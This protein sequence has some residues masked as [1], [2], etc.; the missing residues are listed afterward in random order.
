MHRLPNNNTE[1]ERFVRESTHFQIPVG[2]SFFASP[3]HTL[4]DL[5]RAATTAFD[6]GA[7]AAAVAWASEE[8]A[9]IMWDILNPNV[10]I[11][12]LLVGVARGGTDRNAL[13]AAR[14]IADSA[15]VYLD[16][17][18]SGPIAHFKTYRFR[19][20]GGQRL[21]IVT[22]ANLTRGGLLDNEETATTIYDDGTGTPDV[23]KA[24]DDVD[25]WLLN[26]VGSQ[27]SQTITDDLI[28]ALVEQRIVPAAPHFDRRHR[29]TDDPRATVS[30]PRRPYTFRHATSPI[31]IPP[32]DGPELGVSAFN[33]PPLSPIPPESA[34]R[35]RKF[36]RY[37]GLSES[38]RTRTFRGTHEFNFA[39]SEPPDQEFWRYPSEFALNESG[40]SRERP[41]SARFSVG[42]R[43]EVVSTGRVYQRLRDTGSGELSVTEARLR[44]LTAR[45][46]RNIYAAANIT[47][48]TLLVV[49]PGTDVDYEIHAVLPSDA[50]FL[51]LAPPQG[52]RQAY[53]S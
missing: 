43:S 53:Y 10:R 6:G 49:E 44:P 9:H 41:I 1:S 15:L 52:L 7:L 25:A 17:R 32:Y 21:A 48:D 30:G 27:F 47:P 46:M 16:G 33:A 5:V 36:V 31:V 42:A 8:G 37:Y 14:C 11:E 40:M 23:R 12:Q 22:S 26:R 35:W 50:D 13:F 2:T 34:R 28:Q 38:N 29:S 51:M 39:M 45:A 24:L 4:A 18:V 20:K 3:S 19:A